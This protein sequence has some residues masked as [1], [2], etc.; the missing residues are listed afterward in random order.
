MSKERIIGIIGGLGP[1]AG[2]A[3]VQNIFDQTVAVTDQDHMSVVLLSCSVNINDRSLFLLGK[4]PENP[5]HEIARLL[6]KLELLGSEVA[7][8]ACITSHAPKIFEELKANL[9]KNNSQLLVLHPIIELVSFLRNY[10]PYVSRIGV[11]ATHGTVQSDVFGH[12]LKPRGLTVIYPDAEDQQLLV[13]GSIYDP[14]CGI[15][16]FSNPPTDQARRKLIAASRH[17]ID[18]GA[19]AIVLGCT[20]IPL[21]IKDTVL[22]GAPVID[23]MLALARSLIQHIAPE[24]LKFFTNSTLN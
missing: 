6:N 23:P 20:E 5:A 2:L 8:I 19:E 24:K 3:L 15:K 10:F 22:F 9:Q 4:T 13:H 14:D 11:L 21:A 1:Y 16:A 17:L 18:K 12:Y 7:A